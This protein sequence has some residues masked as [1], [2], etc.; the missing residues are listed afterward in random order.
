MKHV[1][2]FLFVLGWVMGCAHYEGVES[3]DAPA[4]FVTVSGTQFEL[5]DE[6]YAFVGVNFWYGAYI[7]SSDPDIGDLD[8][9]RAELD[10]LQSMGVTN[11][12]IL[13][14]SEDSPLQNSIKPTFQMS[15]G[16]LNTTLLEGL[17]TLLAEMAGR[18]MKAVLYLNNFWEWSGGMA[19]YLSWH[20][21][22]DY[23]EFDAPWPSF[24]IFTSGFYKNAAANQ[25][26]RTYVS[27]LLNRRNTITGRLYKDDPTIMAW[28]LANEPRPGGTAQ[29]G[30]A[31]MEAF[32]NWIDASAAFIKSIDPNHLVSVG[33]EGFIGCGEAPDCFSRIHLSPNVDYAT[34]HMW[35]FNW[36]WIDIDDM[37]ASFPAVERNAANYFQ[38]HLKEAQAFNK[39]VVIEEFGLPRDDGALRP[40]SSTQYRDRFLK[41][42][43][44]EVEL[45]IK[46][47]GP[48]VGSNVWSW[49]GFGRAQHEDYAW[50]N[51][52]ISYTGDPP[53][54]PQ[55]LNSIFD[56]DETTLGLMTAHAQR[57]E[58]LIE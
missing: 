22:G 19:T 31:D 15:D 33:N 32:Y 51:G 24:A 10:L 35:P 3:P 6:P 9:L 41:L 55:G 50:V 43:F 49:G 8:R 38:K 12:R 34:I 11:L 58:D 42:V 53:Q 47:G 5:D 16:Y 7:G 14:A 45:N 18:D 46:T 54:E 20:N 28:Q 13:A 30:Q 29:G 27:S 17:D 56:S 40:N 39:P 36:S 44:D 52:D 25:Q 48:L 57:I 4:G 1:C 37:A 21:G 26:F 2:L 23:V